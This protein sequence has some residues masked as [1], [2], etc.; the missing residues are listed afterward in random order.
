MVWVG[1]PPVARHVGDDLLELI[2]RQFTIPIDI[3]DFKDLLDLLCGN[4]LQAKPY[5]SIFE[6]L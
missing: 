1:D 5:E 4:A 3:K 6:F 2:V